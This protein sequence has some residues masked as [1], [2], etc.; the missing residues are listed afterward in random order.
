[1]YNKNNSRPHYFAYE[2][3]DGV[4]WM[5]PMSS[6][7]EHYR[8]KIE[9][10]KKQ[11]RE[12]IYYEIGVIADQEVVFLISKSFPITSQYIHHAYTIDH[13]HYIVKDRNLIKSLASKIKRYIILVEQG[14]MK[15][16]IDILNLKK[17]LL[18][19]KH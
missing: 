19:Q 5:I 1:M 10:I 12:C 13:V 9:K 16:D 14:K 3:K 11:K 7:V 4:F 17:V 2:D 8:S 6:Q 18:A 15:T